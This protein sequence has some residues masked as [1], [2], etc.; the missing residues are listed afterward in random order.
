MSHE[1]SSVREVLKNARESLSGNPY[2]VAT[3]VGYKMVGGKKSPDLSIVCSVKEK[4]P[5]S[6]LRK[7]DIIASSIDGIPTDIIQ[8]GIIRALARTDRIRPAPGG[9]S[10]GHVN[11]TAGT[12]G[13]VVVKNNELY[14]LSNNHVLANSND[15]QIGDHIIQPGAYD[16]GSY[17]GD[18]IADLSQ[19][20][21]INFFNT[22]GDCSIASGIAAVLNGLAKLINSG[23]RLRPVSI[24][25][26]D[27]LVDAAI[28][29]PVNAGDVSREI[30][31]IGSIQGNIPGELGM[32]IKKSGRTTGLTTGEIIQVDVTANVSYG[33]NKMAVFSD[34]LMAGA[35]S[36]GGDSGS[37]VLTMNNQLTGLLFAG[38]DTTTIINRIENVFTALGVSL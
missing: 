11:I 7:K 25:A 5:T 38:S 24:K 17:P 14:I 30:L 20:V 32:A 22:P 26:V 31:E 36:Q 1:I 37:A 19:F 16:G 28:A 27:N 9:V 13:C 35:M 18:H 10:I 34:Q 21:T 3:G 8:T 29:K 2:V 23:T 4:W 12:L 6:K 33:D 15:G